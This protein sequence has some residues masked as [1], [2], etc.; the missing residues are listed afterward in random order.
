MNNELTNFEAAT[1]KWIKIW[2]QDEAA[3]LCIQW[4][5]THPKTMAKWS[6]PRSLGVRGCP[7]T[8][9]ERIIRRGMGLA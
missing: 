4:V 7:Q 3:E 5:K 6:H 8:A 2:L 9:A 1:I